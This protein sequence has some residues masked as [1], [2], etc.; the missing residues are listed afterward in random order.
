MA[1]VNRWV[2]SIGEWSC[3]INQN[4]YPTRG[5]KVLL[6]HAVRIQNLQVPPIPQPSC[7]S[8]L[9]ELLLHVST[10]STF[11]ADDAATTLQAL[12]ATKAFSDQN[13][14]RLTA[15]HWSDWAQSFTGSTHCASELVSTLEDPQDPFGKVTPHTLS[16]SDHKLTNKQRAS[17]V[18]GVDTPC[19]TICALYVSGLNPGIAFSTP[20]GKICPWAI[21]HDVSEEIQIYMLDLLTEM[22]KKQLI[23]L[24][25]MDHKRRYEEAVRATGNNWVKIR[26]RYRLVKDGGA[27]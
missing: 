16:N 5:N 2:Q 7:Q 24:G 6:S 14:R 17:R 15:E 26:G 8:S 25:T 27:S 18:I 20:S 23:E 10:R 19:C 21:P 4:T 13:W 1:A 12:A 9:T 11:E 22:L 3:A